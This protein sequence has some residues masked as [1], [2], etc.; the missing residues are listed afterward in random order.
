MVDTSSEAF[1]WSILHPNISH[2]LRIATA[3]E[4]GLKK[5]LPPLHG[6]YLEIKG[7]I[8]NKFW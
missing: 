3:W 7:N 2:Q 6:T 8:K 5:W 1:T 4:A